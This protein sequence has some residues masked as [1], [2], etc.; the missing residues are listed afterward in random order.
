MLRARVMLG[1]VFS[2]DGTFSGSSRSCLDKPLMGTGHGHEHAVA[3]GRSGGS[4]RR[5]QGS[6]VVETTC[7]MTTTDPNVTGV[8]LC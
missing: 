8:P 3:R 4:T 7:N 5:G 1:L 2:C 6:F